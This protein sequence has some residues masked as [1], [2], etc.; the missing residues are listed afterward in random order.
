[1]KN[2]FIKFS[3]AIFVVISLFAL[4]ACGGGGGGGNSQLPPTT[5]NVRITI[6]G[7]LFENGNSGNARAAATV[8]SLK[9]S[10]NPYLGN[11]I[12]ITGNEFQPITGNADLKD[13]GD[14]IANLSGLS[15]SCNYRFQVLFGEGANEKVLLQNHVDVASITEGA[16]FKVNDISTKKVLAYEKWLENN[17]NKT[18]NTFQTDCSKEASKI[19]YTEDLYF[20]TLVNFSKNDLKESLVKIT[21]GQQA[22]L[23][24]VDSVDAEKLPASSS[25]GDETKEMVFELTPDEGN[26]VSGDLYKINPTFIIRYSGQQIAESDNKVKIENSITVTDLASDKVVKT[27][28]ADGTIGISFS[29]NL[30]YNTSYTLSM[31]DVSDINGYKVISFKAISFTTVKESSEIENGLSFSLPD[32]AS[33]E[34]VNCPVGAFNMGSL[35]TELGRSTNENQHLVHITKNFYIGKYEVTQA[36]YKALMGKYPSEYSDD[37]SK[38][39]YTISYED[40]KEY[41]AALNTRFANSLPNSYTFDLPTEA[42]WEYACR[43]ETSTSLNSGKNIT[44]AADAECANLNEVGWYAKNSDSTSHPVGQKKPNRWGIYDMHGNVSEWC[45]DW[46]GEDYDNDNQGQEGYLSNDPKGPKTGELRVV[47][48]GGYYSVPSDCRSARRFGLPPT[49]NDNKYLG[50][51]VALVP[52]E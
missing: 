10:A 44:T 41:C 50:F 39:A 3:I 21:S 22:S 35:E 33:L 37:T 34:V 4:T 15:K 9:V 36:Q 13:S 31:S 19:G 16:S 51:R 43:A 47:K 27:W 14:Y 38:P 42:Q 30:A 40:A 8:Q 6:P 24:T 17:P 26:I 23:P 45:N 7:D 28:K 29:E 2:T 52:I 46:Y 48:G 49:T 25:S 18:F 11:G 1:M 20:N 12:P 32:G 5:A